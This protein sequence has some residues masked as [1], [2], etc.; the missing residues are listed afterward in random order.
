[1]VR[2]THHETTTLLSSPAPTAGAS[3][4]VRIKISALWVAM[5]FIFAYVDLFTLYRPDVRA[6]LDDNRL[7]VFDISQTFLA[8][9]TL[10]II[11]PS[12][13]V[14]LSLVMPRSINRAANLIAA[15]IYAVT[16]IGSAI[17]EW[18]Y[19]VMGSIVEVLLLVAVTYHAW[20]WCQPD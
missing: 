15:C 4:D 10:Y 3:I 7:F 20:T 13:M 2:S 17:G 19:F 16:I 18:T 12:L 9:V 8:F 14:Y 6:D 5:L 11:I 1:M